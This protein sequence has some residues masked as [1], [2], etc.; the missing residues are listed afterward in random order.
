LGGVRGDG[1]S[2]VILLHC[3]GLVVMVVNC[4]KIL[5]MVTHHMGSP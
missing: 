2:E 4:H 3:G 5:N 1:L